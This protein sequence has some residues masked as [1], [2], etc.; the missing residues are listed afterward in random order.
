VEALR[1]C[2]AKVERLSLRDAPDLLIGYQGS[3]Y[4][5][6]VKI[7]KGQLTPEQKVWHETWPGQSIVIHSVEEAIDFIDNLNFCE[8]AV[9][10]PRYFSL[11][12][13]SNTTKWR[14]TLRDKMIRK[15]N[16]LSDVSKQ[17]ILQTGFD[18][19][20]AIIPRAVVPASVQWSW[21][22]HC[23]YNI[24]ILTREEHMNPPDRKWA[25]QYLCSMYGADKIDAWIQSLPWKVPP[26]KAW[27]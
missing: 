11:M 7:K 26:E 18:M 23:E 19:H 3:N 6:E 17:S 21:M 10:D 1:R 24:L 25:Y 9:L 15:R 14:A 22:I 12:G 13:N 5:A 27:L 2:G 4:L 20:E 8:S 16:W